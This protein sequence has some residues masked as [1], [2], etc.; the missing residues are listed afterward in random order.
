MQMSDRQ[1]SF[2]TI[3][4]CYGKVF[5][6]CTT[7]YNILYTTTRYLFV[8][9]ANRQDGTAADG[10]TEPHPWPGQRAPILQGASIMLIF[11][12]YSA[13]CWVELCVHFGE[14]G[15]L[16]IMTAVVYC[17]SYINYSNPLYRNRIRSVRI[18]NILPNYY[19]LS[20]SCIT[21]YIILLHTFTLYSGGS[22]RLGHG[23]SIDGFPGERVKPGPYKE[24]HRDRGP[25][26]PFLLFFFCCWYC[27]W[28]WW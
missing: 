25:Q 26:A 19:Y 27:W 21:Q 12:S 18:R 6:L 2:C 7:I 14:D 23:D 13:L 17:A 22:R 9:V 8:W 24:T 10:H 4:E 20:S 28:W 5:I 16:Y 11:V 3:S 1:Y 15:L